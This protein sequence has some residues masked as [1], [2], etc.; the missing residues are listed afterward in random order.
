M[1]VTK[2]KKN[3]SLRRTKGES[4]H[5]ISERLAEKK[6]T[7]EILR[8]APHIF[9]AQFSDFRYVEPTNHDS[10]NEEKIQEASKRERY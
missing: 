3:S 9:M 7:V 2:M 6:R 8:P 1:Q 4:K 5:A 10:K